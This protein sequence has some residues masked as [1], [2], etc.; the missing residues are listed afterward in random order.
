MLP[1]LQLAKATLSVTVISLG[2]IVSDFQ[3]SFTS[4]VSVELGFA[5]WFCS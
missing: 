1:Q 2:I 3:A 4:M 5:S